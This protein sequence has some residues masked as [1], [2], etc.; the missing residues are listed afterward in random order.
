MKS[1]GQKLNLF[2]PNLT[3]INVS[4]AQMRLSLFRTYV[5]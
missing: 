2:I 3:S 4:Q 1:I 5:E